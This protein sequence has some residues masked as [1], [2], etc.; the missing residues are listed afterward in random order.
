MAES[1]LLFLASMT[2]DPYQINASIEL[3][4]TRKLENLKRKSDEIKWILENFYVI[5]CTIHNSV[6]FTYQIQLQ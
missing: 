6:D 5:L 2:L 1:R 4:R 3:Y